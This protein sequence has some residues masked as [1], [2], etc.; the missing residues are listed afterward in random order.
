LLSLQ[1]ASIAYAGTPVLHDITLTIHEGE[2]IAVIGPSGAGKSTLLQ[3]LYKQSPAR[4]AWCP[5]ELGLVGNLSIFHNV[6]MGRLA[7]HHWAYNLLNLIYPQAAERRPVAELIAQLELPD[8]KQAV[9]ALSGGQ[10]QR[11]A[12]ARALHQNAHILIADE[13]VSALD[14]WQSERVLSL[15]GNRHRTVILALHDITQALT[16]CQRI[17]ALKDGRIVLDA[18]ASTLTPEQLQWVYD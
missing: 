16:H 6:Y 15:I 17:I 2:R 11:V 12:V 3:Q 5:Q 10:K 7:Q 13:P 8:M 18:D 1:Q 14:D 4:C 9:D